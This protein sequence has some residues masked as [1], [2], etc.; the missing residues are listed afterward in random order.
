MSFIHS[1]RRTAAA[2]PAAAAGD[3]AAPEATSAVLAGGQAMRPG[4]GLPG[5][6]RSEGKTPDAAETSSQGTLIVGEGIQVKGEIQ[7]CTTLVVE[8]RVE[9]SL[10][11]A[12]LTVREGGVYDGKAVV[13]TARIAG[14][15]SGELTVR[16]L[17]TIAAGGRVAGSL[18]YGDLRIE[19]GGRLSGDVDLL[20]EEGSAEAR[21]RPD[22]EAAAK[23]AVSKAQREAEQQRREAAAR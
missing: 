14:D 7:S 12:E 15:F 10:E 20:A 16:G 9:A 18:R 13:E 8:G 4:A 22:A 6:Q 21:P 23:A 11:A 17:L 1:S 2:A 19:Q 5:L 3:S